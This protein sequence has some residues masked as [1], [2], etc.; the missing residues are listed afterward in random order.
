MR[1]MLNEKNKIVRGGEGRKLV[2]EFEI[3]RLEESGE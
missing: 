2:L 1:R 3:G